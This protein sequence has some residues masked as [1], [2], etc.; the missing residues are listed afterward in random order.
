MTSIGRSGFLASLYVRN[1]K[2]VWL[3][4]FFYEWLF[5]FKMTIRGILVYDITDDA[6]LTGLVSAGFA[7]S[8]LAFFY[9][10]WCNR[11]KVEKRI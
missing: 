4:L 9:V 2:Y 11:E 7:P 5:R 6:F 1:F 3:S 8:L 10:W